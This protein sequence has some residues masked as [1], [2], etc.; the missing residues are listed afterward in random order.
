MAYDVSRRTGCVHRQRATLMLLLW[1]VGTAVAQLSTASLR[2]T[3][4]DPDGRVVADAKIAIRSLVNGVLER[5]A[6]TNQAGTYAAEALSPG[7]YEVTITKQGFAPRV[8]QIEVQVGRVVI[9]DTRLKLG[10]LQERIAVTTAAPLID[11]Q[12]SDLGG[13]VERKVIE[14]LPLN[15]RQFGELASLLP[16]VLPA[17]NYVFV[18]TR[19]FHIS[20][21]G[22]DGRQSNFSVDGAENTDNL[23]G[24]MQQ[25][26]TIEGIQEFK[27]SSNRYDAEQGRTLGAA[28]NVVTKSGGNTL[29]GSYFVFYRNQELNANDPFER[30][31]T[32]F[33]RTQQGLTFGGP[34]R[35]DQSF[36]FVAFENTDEEDL[37][38][39]NTNGTFR[40]FEGSFPLPFTA[41]LL[42]A[43]ADHQLNEQQKVSIRYG[44]EN[45]FSTDG[46][47]GIRSAENGVRN[48]NRGSDL[49]ASYTAAVTPEVQNTLLYH[50]S[51][52]DSQLL[53]LVTTPE[54]VRP[55]LI[56]GGSYNTPYLRNVIRHQVRNDT[57]I[58]A[59]TSWGIHNLRFGADYTHVEI[60]GRL[61]YDARGRFFFFRDAP[62]SSTSANL[63]LFAVG[64]FDL[65]TYRDNIAGTY[66]QDDWKLSRTFMLNLGLRWDVSTNE[67]NPG[68][69]SPLPR[70][71]S[72]GRDFNNLG[73]RVGFAWDPTGSGKMVFRGGYGIFYALPVATNP[74]IESLFDSRRVGVGMFRGPID[75]NNPFPGLTQAEINA[76]VFAQPQTLLVTLK[77]GVR[78]S[79]VQQSSVGMQRQLTNTMTLTLDYVH[80]L[81]LKERLGHDV[82]IDATGR[83]GSPNTQL[84]QE[85]G[86]GVAASFGPVVRIDDSARSTYNAL[87][88]SLR[89]HFSRG[90]CF[91]GSYTLS[92]AVDMS[93]DSIGSAAA[94]PF[95]SDKER[96]D[97]NRDQRHRF[98]LSGSAVLPKGFEVASISSFAS[99]RPFDIVTGGSLDGFAPTRPPGISRNQG[100]RDT[101]AVLAA[102]NAARGTAGLSSVITTSPRSFFFYSTDLRLT[103]AFEFRDRV[104]ISAVVEA[105]NIFNHVNFL[106]NGGAFLS[107]VPS[108]Q[109]DVLA[110][111]FGRPRR[112]AG[113]V[114]GSGGPRAIQ[115]AF[116]SEF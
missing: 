41:R 56:I 89:R 42:T 50:F 24:G 108:V 90:L 100:A 31:K 55:S 88:A 5:T 30:H 28:V 110:R 67:N 60:N 106:S 76:L 73:P 25:N 2:G 39:V 20:A 1:L 17:P 84:A 27:V 85:L 47:G 101:P 91:L 86:P 94:L 79:Y 68:F 65:P 46:I 44:Y 54:V 87:E 34:I 57:A 59:P 105:F 21:G 53:P 64:N 93:D 97:S 92:H 18:K 70:Q 63:A 82:N 78:T 83:I 81:G 23:S 77:N 75:I 69:N 35:K 16:G 12:R 111:D 22:A 104:R 66:V 29:H 11:L 26:F 112:T 8:E 80:N 96:G 102:I 6:R 4:T 72:R 7:V 15:G 49:A 13:V 3:I 107:G 33:H 109:N 71:R 113:G 9:L 95:N 52:F 36:F 32:T 58:T 99:A 116:R 48:L 114:L 45:N 74:V 14:R 38:I 19:F 51:A 10:L 98:V 62:L 40:Q 115:L 103:K 61:E 37:G 43:R